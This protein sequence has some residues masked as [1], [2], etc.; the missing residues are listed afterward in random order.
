M[1]ILFFITP[2]SDVAYIYSDDTI[3]QVMEK[4]E[5]H[6]YSCVPIIDREGN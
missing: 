1:N 4:M 3:R 5:H 2:K 6:R